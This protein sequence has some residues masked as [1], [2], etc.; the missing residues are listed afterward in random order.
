VAI[1]P[2][3][4]QQLE[5]AE[6][7]VEIV[8]QAFPGRTRLVALFDS[9]SA[10]QFEAA[11]RAAKS[12]NMQMQPLKIENPPYDFETA[13]R[14]ASAASAD[15]VLVLSSP[16]F[17]EQSSRIAALAIMHRLP[18]MFIFRTYVDAGGLMSMASISRTC[19]GARRTTSPKFAK[20]GSPQIFR[21]N[22]PT[23][24]SSSS[25]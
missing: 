19:S 11:E 5:L 4:F 16:F 23:S 10:D 20:A 22:K 13:F 3:F 18:T 17:G 24:L 25:T 9:Q 6:K 2:A 1:L 15:I 21:S 7:Q 8:T 14:N 12:L